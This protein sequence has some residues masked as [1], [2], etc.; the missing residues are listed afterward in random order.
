MVVYCVTNKVNGKRYVGKTIGTVERRWILHVSEAKNTNKRRAILCAIRKYGRESF[1]HEVLQ[2][3][4]TSEEL[5]LAEITW[6][7]KLKTT[8]SKNGYNETA[9]GE[10]LSMPTDETKKKMSEAHKGKTASFETKARMS[11][12]HTGKIISFQH[13][14]TLRMLKSKAVEGY[15]ME[16]G[17]VKVRFS[18]TIEAERISDK[19]Y[20]SSKISLVC[21]GKRS[22]HRGLGWRYVNL[23]QGFDL[24]IIDPVGSVV[25][26][27]V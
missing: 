14:E 16:T 25:K 23:E 9:G 20:L 17:E 4:S 12:A 8:D 15:C 11:A 3:C 1:E 2:E 19:F 26:S 10:G 18:S 22:H 7:A 27:L 6:I 5:T 13:R 24:N 21:N